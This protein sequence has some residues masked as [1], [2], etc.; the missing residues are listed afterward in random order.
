M[1]DRC[2][3]R[4]AEKLHWISDEEILLERTMNVS[5]IVMADAFEVRVLFHLSGTKPEGQ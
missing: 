5:G 4:I 3:A 1:P 2:N